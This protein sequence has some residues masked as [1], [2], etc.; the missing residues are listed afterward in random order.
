MD[1]KAEIIRMVNEIED[2]E[3]LKQIYLFICELL[4]GKKEKTVKP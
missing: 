1:Y 2:A 3:V 4:L